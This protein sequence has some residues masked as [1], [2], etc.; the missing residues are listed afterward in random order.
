LCAAHII[1][2]FSP[3]ERDVRR[4][5]GGEGPPPPPLQASLESRLRRDASCSAGLRSGSRSA[6]SAW[7]AIATA[8]GLDST[9]ASLRSPRSTIAALGRDARAARSGEPGG[10]LAI[11]T[12]GSLDAPV[13]IAY[14]VLRSRALRLRLALR[15]CPPLALTSLRS[16]VLRLR[17]AICRPPLLLCPVS[18]SLLQ[19]A[20]VRILAA[21]S[22]DAARSSTTPVSTAYFVS[23]S[24]ALRLRLAHASVHRSAIRVGGVHRY[25]WHCTE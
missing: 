20:R 7:D 19:N 1:F 24:R 8:F 15:R 23:R 17:L 13:S 22:N 12:R 5:P 9:D 16:R 21:R 4:E 10:M 25:A 14:I 6:S 11:A 3:A 18:R 2:C